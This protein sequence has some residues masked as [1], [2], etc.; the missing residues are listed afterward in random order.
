MGHRKLHV[1]VDNVWFRLHF[2]QCS[3]NW[4]LPKFM[5]SINEALDLACDLSDEG[6]IFMMVTGGIIYD[7]LKEYYTHF[8]KVIW[9][10]FL[11]I[12]SN[13]WS[14]SL[15]NFAKFC[16]AICH[17]NFIFMKRKFIADGKGSF[18][19]VMVGG[20]LEAN[21][22]WDIGKEVVNCIYKDYA[23]TLPIRPKVSIFYSTS[24]NNLCDLATIFFPNKIIHSF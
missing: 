8:F 10:C 5:N 11:S 16:L 13:L 4:S 24:R 6:I 17:I 20:V 3:F 7:L 9:Y 23:G 18:P 14:L 21:K 22:T 1:L 19:L 2:S 12:D 15:I